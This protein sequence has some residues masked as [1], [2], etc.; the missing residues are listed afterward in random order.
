MKFPFASHIVYAGVNV[1]PISG[2][3]TLEADTWS[4]TACGRFPDWSVARLELLGERLVNG[5]MVR[6]TVEIDD[7]HPL[8]AKVASELLNRM[9]RE[10]DVVWIT[11]MERTAQ[12]ATAAV[13]D[14]LRQMAERA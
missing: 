11:H 4:R 1:A 13:V 8:Y 7:E 3:A 12:R 5:A 6:A 14:S 9:R 10:I 2:I